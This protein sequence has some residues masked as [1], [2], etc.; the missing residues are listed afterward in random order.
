[1]WV[2]KRCESLA[3]TR[4]YYIVCGHQCANRQLRGRNSCIDSYAELFKARVNSERELFGLGIGLRRVMRLKTTN[5]VWR[6][7]SMPSILTTCPCDLSS[8]RL[9]ILRIVVV[10]QYWAPEN[11]VPQRRWTWLTE[12]LKREG[13][14]V[15]VIAPPPHYARKMSLTSWARKV[16]TD[17]HN[18]ETGPSGERIL[19]CFYLPAGHSLT[20]R[21]MSQ[22]VAA[23]SS[24][25]AFLT[26]RGEL[27]SFGA[28]VVIG[29]VPALPT[30]V[31]AMLGA[32]SLKLPYVIDLRDA[33]P[34]L[35]SEV[36]KWNKGLGRKSLRERVLRKGPLQLI[37]FVT[38]K[39]IDYSLNHAAALIVTSGLYALE[40]RRRLEANGVATIPVTV[41]RNVFPVKSEIAAGS[42]R[43]LGFAKPEGGAEPKTLKVLYAG[44][45]GRAQGLEN[46]IL[47]AEKAAMLG[48]EVDL[49]LIGA[50][51]ARAELEELA[52]RSHANVSILDRKPA[53]ELGALYNWADTLLVHLS[54]W[55]GLEYAVPSKTFEFFEI[56]K[57]ITGAVRGEA[58]YLIEHLEAGD[59]V[60]PGNPEDLASLWRELVDNP[61]K[62]QISNKAQSWLKNE[63]EINTCNKLF[64]LLE[65]L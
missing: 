61:S 25:L 52:R 23:T 35:L 16:L 21:A 7:E 2:A 53:D 50:G 27:K 63:R 31:V 33:W 24:L 36:D 60:E 41:I 47:A 65:S 19:R 17:S 42:G 59:V 57:H 8:G 1:M 20:M 49:R 37:S 6:L 18:V 55:K 12:Q 40:M 30:T 14:Q 46:A 48:V 4:H 45:L 51:A 39:V 34:D 5:Q 64:T 15:L 11:G 22:A 28:D 44:T 29:T 62:L 32:K 56:G 38:S 58:A 9:T 3:A 13:H 26:K 10:S 43:E 54:D